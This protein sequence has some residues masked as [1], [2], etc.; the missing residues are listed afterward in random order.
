MEN[1]PATDVAGYVG[2]EDEV[3]LHTWQMLKGV[4]LATL[5]GVGTQ[6]SR[7]ISSRRCA[8]RGNVNLLTFRI[9]CNSDLR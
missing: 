6:L 4:A 8:K 5:I 9:S 7:A 1:L 3:D 2:L